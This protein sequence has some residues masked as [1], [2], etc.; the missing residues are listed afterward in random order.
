MAM[1][2]QLATAIRPRHPDFG[3]TIAVYPS[4]EP[5]FGAELERKDGATG[6]TE[7]F[8][9]IHKFTW[10]DIQ[11]PSSTD[12]QAAYVYSDILPNDGNTYTY[13]ARAV[14]IGYTASAYTSQIAAQP[15]HGTK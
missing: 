11:L 2:P 10:R 4:T 8:G 1:P 15:V 12:Q 7:A 13:R 6:S 9:L 14:A 5:R 3:I